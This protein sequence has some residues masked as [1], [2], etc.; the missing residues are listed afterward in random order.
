MNGTT[1]QHVDLS[2]FGGPEQLRAMSENTLPEPAPGQ[3]RVRAPAAGTGFTDTIIRRGQ[4]VGVEQKPPFTLGYDCFG[5]V[6]A[7]DAG[8][9]SLRPGDH[10]AEMPVVG[11]D[12][13]YPC[14]DA[15]RVVP[16]PA[17][18][19]PAEAFRMILSCTMAWQMLTRECRLQA[20]ARNGRRSSGKICRP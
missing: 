2:A 4:Y 16:C 19:D 5:V 13:R 18:L 10:V 15:S 3:V 9:E 17:R 6:D 20:G 14:A 1:W 8:V 12:T 7:S 11:G